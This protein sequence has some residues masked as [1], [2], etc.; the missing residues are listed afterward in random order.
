MHFKYKIITAACLFFLPFQAFAQLK[1]EDNGTKITINSIDDIRVGNTFDL[2]FSLQYPQLNSLSI[3]D[4]HLFDGGRLEQN[5]FEDITDDLGLGNNPNLKFIYI[6]D[7]RFTNILSQSYLPKLEKLMVNFMLYKATANWLF[8]YNWDFLKNLPKLRVLYVF[9]ACVSDVT[10]LLSN[11]QICE[12]IKK[13][14][15]LSDGFFSYDRPECGDPIRPDGIHQSLILSLSHLTELSIYT[16]GYGFTQSD[17]MVYKN[18]EKQLKT[19]FPKATIS[20]ELGE[21]EPQ[22]GGW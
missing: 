16:I 21:R 7:L 1:V 11:V 3:R 13:L 17:V 6:S 20:V 8:D 15:I 22:D 2:D 4:K 12:N 19:K 9:D 10:G 18:L 5:P 14:S